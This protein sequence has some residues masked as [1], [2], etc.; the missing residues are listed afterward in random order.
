MNKK[1]KTMI[2]VALISTSLTAGFA[3][4]VSAASLNVDTTVVN[5]V[6]GASTTDKK[7]VITGEYANVRS[8]AGQSNKKLGTVKNGQSFTYLDSKKA[9][10]T[11]VV[12]YKIQYTSSQTGWVCSGYS[13]VTGGNATTTSNKKV[14]ITG[15][16]ANAVSYTHLTLPTKRIV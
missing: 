9:A 5:A 16:T 1:M 6:S 4:P 2:A 14:V 10:S 11:G 12:W 8:D 7:V 15:T 3:V 13:K